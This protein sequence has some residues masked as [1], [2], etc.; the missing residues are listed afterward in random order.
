MT[1]SCR[2]EALERHRIQIRYVYEARQ[3]TMAMTPPMKHSLSHRYRLPIFEHSGLK[4]HNDVQ[5][6]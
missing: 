2:S 3:M 6:F 5:H 1:P 4:S